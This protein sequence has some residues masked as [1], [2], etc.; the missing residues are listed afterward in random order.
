MGNVRSSS[1]DCEFD[2]VLSLEG[3]YL[4]N[5]KDV[6]RS[7]GD[8]KAVASKKADAN[9]EAE[10]IE[11]AATSGTEVD[12]RGP[13]AKGKEENVI[14]TVISFDKGGVWSYLKPPKVDSLGKKIDCPPDRCWLHLHGITNFHNYAPFYSTENAVGIIMGTG[15][16]GPYLR[17][18][19]DQTNT[20]LSRDG[21]LTFVEAH[22]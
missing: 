1:G 10:E 18:E 4:A 2:K 6:P 11:K 14:R 19:P 15:C 22:K 7:D 13:K 3:V 17:F 16:V 8:S 12:K 21:G 5:F 9:K 20:Y